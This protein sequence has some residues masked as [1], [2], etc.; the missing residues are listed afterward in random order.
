VQKVVYDAA[1]AVKP[2]ALIIGVSPHPFFNDTQDIVRTYDVATFD[3][4]VHLE[5]ARYVRAVA[6]G[7]VP[8]LDE[9]VYHQNFFR[10]MKEAG[11]LGIPMIYNLL[12]FNGDG[13]AYTTDDYRR[14]REILDD[15]VERNE[16]LKRHFSTLPRPD[17]RTLHTPASTGMPQKSLQRH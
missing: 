1:K 2:D 8:A 13:V 14:L 9:H 7:M 3:P 4:R 10:Y 5:R 11:E 17:S 16:P 12:K 15:Y 6:P